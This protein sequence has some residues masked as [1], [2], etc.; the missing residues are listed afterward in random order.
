MDTAT[1]TGADAAKTTFKWVVQKTTE[2]TG[3][4][5]SKKNSW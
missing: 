2:A 4:F 3:K 1:N 5:N